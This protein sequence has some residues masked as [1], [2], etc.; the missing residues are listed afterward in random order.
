MNK[1]EWYDEEKIVFEK[2]KNSLNKVNTAPEA[3]LLV[4]EAPSVDSPGR[5]YYSNFG[6]FIQRFWVPDG[7]SDDEKILYKNFIEKL[8]K[9]GQ[10]KSGEGKIIINKLNNGM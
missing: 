9:T 5:K 1:Q 2:F 10:L 6:F 4:R 8:D 3:Q 7:A